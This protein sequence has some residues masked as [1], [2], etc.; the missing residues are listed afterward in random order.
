M[1]RL[2]SDT[3]GFSLMELVWAMGLG[4]IVLLAAFTV[5]DKAFLA[6]KTVSDREDALQRGR[7]ALEL[8]TRQLRSQVCLQTSPAT[9]PITTGQDQ[10]I[11]FYAYLGDP[12]GA[13][14]ANGQR[15]AGTNQ[16][17]PEQ[18]TISYASNK[19]SESDAKVTSF[20]PLTVASAYRTTVLATNVVLPNNKLFQYY[21]GSASGG[22]STTALT[23]PLSASDAASVVQIG[24]AYKVLPTKITNTSNAQA[25]SFQDNVFFRSVSPEDTTSQPCDSN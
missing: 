25:T 7:Q 13:T 5:V 20:S 23:T 1:R 6:N 14:V 19:I 12:T 18:H 10:S 11:T 16:V 24:V 21:A 17:Y 4:I 2:R 15:D 8:I 9:L 22:V 3:R